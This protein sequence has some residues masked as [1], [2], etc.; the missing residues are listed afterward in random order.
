MKKIFKKSIVSV[1]AAALALTAFTACA[2]D[3]DTGTKYDGETVILLSDSKITADGKKVGSSGD[4]FVS[5]DVIYYEDRDTYDSGNRYGEGTDKDKHTAE[6]AAS[7]TVVNIAKAG[8]YRLSGKLSNGQIRID[9][10]EDAYEDETAV[11]TLVLDGLDINCDVAPAVVFMNVYECDG[12]W[13]AETAKMD[14][15]T[16]AAGANVVIADG[17]INNIEGAYV[18]KI[19]KDNDKEKKLWKQDGAFYS[20]MSMNIDGEEE[21]NGV[22]NI[23]AD[24]E[25]LCAELH[26]SINGGNINIVSQ[27]DGINTN[28]DGVSVTAINGGNLRIISGMGAEGGDG[29]DSNGWIVANGGTTVSVAYQMTDSGI[30]NDNGFYAN[31]GTVI[32]YGSYVDWAEPDSRQTTLNLQFKED[33]STEDAVVITDKNGN[34]VF[35]YDASEDETIG[36]YICDRVGVTISSPQLKAGECCSL[37]IGGDVE[38]SEYYGIYDVNT[39]KNFKDAVQQVQHSSE[40]FYHGGFQYDSSK[41]YT[42]TTDFN[43]DQTV[44]CFALIT[45]ITD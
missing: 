36:R 14:V 16:S 3:A 4:I 29:I 9:L 45:D 31:G 8:I 37:Y 11:V 32:S 1:L 2:P 13:S 7:V 33:I 40:V 43:L 10:G 38:G 17:S 23:T 28:E 19:F 41:V 5:N 12:D 18:A 44:N 22:L 35:C 25:G 26:L 30:D 6:E 42:P 24:N 27:D 21:G 15:D 34:V 20:Y 39:V